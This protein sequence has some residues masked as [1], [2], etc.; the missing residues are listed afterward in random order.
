[1]LQSGKQSEVD[2]QKMCGLSFGRFLLGAFGSTTVAALAASP[3]VPAQYEFSLA[4]SNW[5]FQFSC[6]SARNTVQCTPGPQAVRL[7]SNPDGTWSFNFPPYPAHANYL[8]TPGVN[9]AGHRSLSM[10]FILT[11]NTPAW[12][13]Q[14]DANN[15]CN[16]GSP[17]FVHLYFQRDGDDLRGTPGA[18]EYY[19]WWSRGDIDFRSSG[20]FVLT[21]P[22]TMGNWTDVLGQ[23]NITSFPMF[24]AAEQN[25]AYIGMTFGGGCFDGHGVAVKNGSAIFTLVSLILD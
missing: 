11:L 25:V 19:R 5:Q 1:V 21:V 6:T 24:L 12:F 23:D 4:T 13:W 14:F 7:L 16:I 17:P 22:L 9:L 15:D 10:T 20:R 18:T 8:I 3:T 2:R